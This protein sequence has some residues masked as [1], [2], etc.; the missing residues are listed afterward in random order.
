[1]PTRR[2]FLAT[3]GASVLWPRRIERFEHDLKSAQDPWDRVRA[4]FSIPSDRVYL[5]I[6]TLGPQPGA[7][8]DAVLEHSRRVAM[9][10][11]PGVEWDA[12][13]QAVAALL[14]CDPAGLVFP[15]NTTEGMNFVA[16][17]LDLGTGDEVITTNHEHVGGLSCW[18]LIARR[19][20]I[21]LRQVELPA[22]PVDPAA[23]LD[24]LTAAIT[25]RTRVLSVSHVNF[26]NGLIM[27]VRQLI[28]H[29]RP[30]GIIVVVDGAHPPG[31]MPVDLKALDPDFYASSPHKW[32]FAAQGT[33]LLYL[34]EEWRTRLWPTLASGGWDDLGLGAHRF[35]H[36]GTFD[37]SRLA[38]LLAAVRFHQAMGADRVHARIRELRR[39]LTGLLRESPRVQLMSPADD[40]AGAGMV[41][42]TMVGLPALELQKKLAEHNVRTRVIGEYNYNWMRLSASV[43]NTR[44][45][46]ERV[47]ALIQKA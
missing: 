31:M 19:R 23:V 30:R 32:L 17:G 8:V 20:G 15:R 9:S 18:Q 3:A 40:R 14:N 26:T 37:E 39:T 2:D 46:L 13:K 7:V 11:P 10:L 25:S 47:A 6:G 33:G 27:P 34:R 21:G 38:G 45:E 16:Q 1:M 36:L 22:L 43:Y 12:L 44:T 5:N 42:F 4:E 24:R 35:N 28:E 29:C 41:A